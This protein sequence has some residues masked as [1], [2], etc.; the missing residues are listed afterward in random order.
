MMTASVP[1]ANALSSLRSLS[2]GANS[3]ER[4]TWVACA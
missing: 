3:S 1:L 2:A 4:I